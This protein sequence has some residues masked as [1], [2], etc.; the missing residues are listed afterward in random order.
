ML[1][2]LMKR[3]FSVGAGRGLDAQRFNFEGAPVRMQA[4]AGAVIEKQ[5]LPKVRSGQTVLPSFLKSAKPDP[6]QALL[7]TDRLLVNT[8]LT[9]LRNGNDSRQIIADFARSTP[10]LSA[11]VT[12]YVRT[13]VTSGWTALAKNPDGTISPEATAALQ[14]VIT[15]FN[16]MNDYSLGYDD[17]GSIRSVSE[18]WAWE[19]LTQ[20]AM[21]GELVLNKAR[22]PDKVQPIAVR[23]IEWLP[24]ADAKRLVPQQSIA[25]QKIPLNIPTFFYVALDSDLTNPY[26]ISP[27]E[28][29]IQAVLFSAQFM[30]DIR[31]VVRK[32]IHPRVDVTIDE[33]KFRKLVP[34][35]IS[36]D[37]EKMMAWM[38]AV[39]SNLEGKINGLEPEDA[40]V[41]FDT[42][43]LEVVDH[44]NTNLSQ[45]YAVLQGMADAK[46]ASGAK[47]MPTV[48]GQGKGTSN[49]ASAETLMFMKYVEGTVW[50]KLNE[51]WS[52]MLTLGV[53]LL[54][55][56][57]YVEFTF[58]PIDLRPEN[59]LEAFKAMRQSR[60]MEQLSLGFITDE[61]AAIALTGHLPPAGFKTL[62]GTMFMTP[63]KADPAGDGFNGASNKGSTMNQKIESDAPKNAKSKNGGQ[64]GAE[65]IPLGAV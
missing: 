25:G 61:E 24:S 14:Q 47:V 3:F 5:P 48:L 55:H 11:A 63:G 26:A 13:G 12:A 6:K 27:I 32:A 15:W 30:N 16:V 17:G 36:A 64:K 4:A 34:P 41:H 40:L 49:T 23:Q 62:S 52:K 58:N 28:P 33:E 7:R 50:G 46:L 31:R 8:D 53:R 54:G 65:V 2:S 60:L 10:D 45:E 51:M 35:E 39:I 1:G 22:L 38:D 20:G 44:G 56:D 19:L 29:A 21:A 9:S 42:I 43:G 37:A 18:Q 59:E 57:V